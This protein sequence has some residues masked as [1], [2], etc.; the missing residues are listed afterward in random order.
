[1]TQHRIARLQFH[2]IR[3]VAILT[4]LTLLTGIGVVSPLRLVVA[5]GQ[6]Q[7]DNGKARKVKTLAA[8]EGKASA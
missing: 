7:R 3:C 2:L 1:M 8:P 5:E 4:S 6:G